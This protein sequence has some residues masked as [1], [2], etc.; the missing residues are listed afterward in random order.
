MN[1]ITLI[2]KLSPSIFGLIII[3]FFM[4]F[5]NISCA[6]GGAVTLTGLQLV[7]GTDIGESD[8]HSHGHSRDSFGRS[9]SESVSPQPLVIAV[10]ICGILGLVLSFPRNLEI[11]I[12]PALIGV[13]GVILLLFFKYQVDN[14][15]L[16]EGEGMLHAQYGIGFWLTFIFII[17]AIILNVF[18]F[19]QS[20][21]QLEDEVID[22]NTSK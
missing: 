1:N 8:S 14:A 19:F 13:I 10:L 7:T 5:V 4:P 22:S 17:I 3:C 9:Q 16:E 21:K 11:S 15:I 2:K 18:L 6:G 12:I 20:K